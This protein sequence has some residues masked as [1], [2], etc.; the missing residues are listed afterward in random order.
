MATTSNTHK[1]KCKKKIKIHYDRLI[2]QTILLAGLIFLAVWLVSLCSSGNDSD[3]NSEPIKEAV[4]AGKRDAEKVLHTVPGSM[5]RDAAL[6]F[7][8]SREHTLRMK[9]HAHAADDYI[10]SARHFLAEHGIE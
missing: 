5:E 2:V 10:E 1:R 7:I 9:G 3:D 4:E 8:R 6:L